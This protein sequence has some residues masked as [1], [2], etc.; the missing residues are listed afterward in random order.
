MKLVNR[1]ANASAG[2]NSQKSARYSV[3]YRSQLAD[4]FTTASDC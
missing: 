4:Q 2:Q 3:Y 1:A